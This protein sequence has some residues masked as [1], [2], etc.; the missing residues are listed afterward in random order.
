MKTGP[1][2][3]YG[4]PRINFNFIYSEKEENDHFKVNDKVFC[5][6]DK[7][8]FTITGLRCVGYL[9]HNNSNNKH[10]KL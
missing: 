6:I 3:G 1:S 4:K 2:Q 10:K 9:H 8:F 5:T 7:L